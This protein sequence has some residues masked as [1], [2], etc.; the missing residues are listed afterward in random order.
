MTEKPSNGYYLMAGQQ[1]SDGPFSTLEGA[2]DC[3]LALC[4]IG[5]TPPER[6]GMFVAC[7]DGMALDLVKDENGEVINGDLVQSR[8][9]DYWAG[10]SKRR[11][12]YP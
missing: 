7:M 9:M 12:E 3:L 4:P 5:F 8:E 11:P 1:I 6:L 2:A 10:L